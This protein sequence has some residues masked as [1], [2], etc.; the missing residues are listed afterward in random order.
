[1]FLVLKIIKNWHFLTPL[2]LQVITYEWS[3]SP[4]VSQNVQTGKLMLHVRDFLENE[5]KSEEIYEYQ[6]LCTRKIVK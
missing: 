2:P 1:M 4:R 3:L 6:S 5:T